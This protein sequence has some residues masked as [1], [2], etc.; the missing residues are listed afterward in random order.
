MRL[1]LLPLSSEPGEAVGIHA[2]AHQLFDWP[3]ETPDFDVRSTQSSLRC[4]REVD[5]RI[6]ASCDALWLPSLSITVCH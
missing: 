5:L 2:Q 3:V 4:V 1:V 6:S